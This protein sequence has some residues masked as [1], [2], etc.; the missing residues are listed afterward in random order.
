MERLQLV[1]LF[2]GCSNE[3]EV[4]LKSASA[5]IE[6]LDRDL[7]NVILVGITREG[8]WL[9]YEGGI[10][11]IRADRWHKHA[12]C[13]SAFLTPCREIK[14]L[15]ELNNG[16]SLVT[17]IDAVFPMLHGKNGEDGTV[18]GLL[19][20]SSI[21]Y[22]GCDML[23]SV[24]C[25]DKAIAHALVHAAGIS[26][27][28][29]ITMLK[30]ENIEKTIIEAEKL[31]YPLYIKPAKSGSSIG[32]TKASDQEEL[33]EGIRIAFSHDKKV[34]IEQN[35]IGFEVGCA[36][37]GNTSTNLIVGEV[38]EIELQV[39][40]DFFDYQE[41]YSLETSVIHLPARVSATTAEKIKETAIIIYRTLGC[42]GL[43]RVDLFLTPEGAIV[44]NEVNTMPGFTAQSRY[45]NMLHASGIT[46][47]MLL[48]R[49]IALAVS[50][51]E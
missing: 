36:V 32:I 20:L 29:S 7:Y 44:F 40:G 8:M 26:T 48:N 38:D 13:R 43:A 2:G 35:I 47:P 34:V 23:S 39:E 33:R 42:S 51:A 3:Y 31:G 27:A 12:S 37:L 22:I 15:V 21:P 1:V 24:L 17:P 50:E 30:E 49:L 19:E 18:Q 9:R 11:D 10:A 14:G 45:P 5:V 4:S 28:Q 6:N 16:A 41:K 25:M 46:F